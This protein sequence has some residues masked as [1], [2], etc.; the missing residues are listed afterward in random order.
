MAA[1]AKRNQNVA[2]GA[3]I[4][5][6][7]HIGR[8]LGPLFWNVTYRELGSEQIANATPLIAGSRSRLPNH[9]LE[10]GFTGLIFRV[11]MIQPKNSS[12]A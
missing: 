1:S 3:K 5:E 7:N 9:L 10:R 11:A 6:L 2:V 12:T 4:D 8:P